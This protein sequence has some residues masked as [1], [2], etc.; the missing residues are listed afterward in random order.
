M[1]I[2]REV[3]MKHNW[4]KVICVFGAFLL[5]KAT[6]VDGSRI[7]CIYPSPGRS[8]V[9]VGQALLKGLAERGHQVTMV[10]PFKL[11]KPVKN[12]REVVVPVD[13]YVSKMTKSFLEKPPNMLTAFPNMMQKMLAVAND[14]VNY[15]AFVELKKEKF[16]LVIVGLF[17]ADFVLGYGTYFGAPTVVLWTGGNTKFTSDLVGNP[18]AIESAA[19]M[20]LGPQDVTKFTS[21]LKSFLIA[22]VENVFTAYGMYKQKPYYDWNFPSDRYPSYAEVRRN[23]SLVLLNTHFSH[24]GA[25]PYLQNMVEVGGLQIKPKPDPL[26]KDIQEWLDGAGEHGAIY[27]CLGS[28]LKSADLPVEKMEIF[29]KS[30]GKLKQRILWKWETDSFPGQPA[31]VMAKKWLPQDDVLAH[32]NVVLFI[33]HGGLGGIAEARYHGVPILGIPIFAEQAGNMRTVQQEGWGLEVDYMNLNA[34]TF[35][36]MVKDVLTNPVYRQKAK[37]ISA[38]YRDRP[39]TAMETACYWIEYVIRHRGATHMHYQGAD[40]S[41]I[42][43]LMLDVIAVIGLVLFLIFKILAFVGKRAVRL[44]CGGRKKQKV[45]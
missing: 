6:P 1:M 42:Q 34:V 16:D 20:L 8:H 33:A 37:Q 35:E 7:L 41:F 40:L 29:V 5:P 19:N 21:R 44:I 39:Q 31:N 14:T 15:P 43:M 32:K 36:G 26:P 45:H 27:F 4:L 9:I 3:A 23:V 2:G 24:G 30:L 12:Y 22:S 28:N 38:V 11:S 18:R 25:R 17:M 13:D 10:S